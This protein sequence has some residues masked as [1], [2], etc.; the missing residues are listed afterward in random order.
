[1][2]G[3][4]FGRRIRVTIGN[5]VVVDL[6]PNESLDVNEARNL[7]VD[8]NVST[9]AKPEPLVADVT[10]K[11]LNAERRQALANQQERARR[12]A[13]QKYQAVVVGD[14]LVEPDQVAD[15]S[16]NLVS[17]GATI[18]IEAGYGDDFGLIH[19]GIVLPDGLDDNPDA[20]GYST[21]FRSQDN[22]L[23]WSNAFVSEEVAPGVTLV[24]YQQA[25]AV[26]EQYKRGNI[27]GAEVE[28]A[29]PGILERKL[30]VF[31]YENGKVLH[32]QTRDESQKLMDTLGLRAFLVDG[33][34]YYLS[35]EATL[36][37]EAVVLQ[38]VPRDTRVAAPGGLLQ[39]KQVGRMWQGRCLLN[40]RM[41]AGRQLKLLWEDGSPIGGGIFK[42][43][44]ATHTGSSYAANY[45]TEFVAR[46]TSIKAKANG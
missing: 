1:M 24:D 34:P 46:P 38:L 6:D 41:S 21:S 4:L 18:T 3:E 27:G 19:T 13:W 37:T 7:D 33:K 45:Y 9:H 11:N 17:Q 25:L 26:A 39:I 36:F 40:H 8:F 15:A 16:A 31:G 20:P 30:D 35:I 28:A 43:E 32:G 12:Q 10:V 29:A 42:V 22:R 5:Q 23:P 44:H 2:I 14:V